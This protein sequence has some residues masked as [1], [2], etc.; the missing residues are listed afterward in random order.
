MYNLEY[1]NYVTADILSQLV[2]TLDYHV[3]C[4]I[5]C[6]FAE[7][8]AAGF[9]EENGTLTMYG[10]RFRAEILCLCS[11]QILHRCCMILSFPLSSVSLD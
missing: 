9:T 10:R 8:C 11:S 4:S 3:M 5:S 7:A 6:L 2:G 1:G